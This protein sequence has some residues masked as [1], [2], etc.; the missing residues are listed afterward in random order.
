ML[1]QTCTSRFNNLRNNACRQ[2]ELVNIC[3]VQPDNIKRVVGRRVE[4]P[5]EQLLDQGDRGD[6]ED[7]VRGDLVGDG[8][9]VVVGGATGDV[10]LDCADAGTFCSVRINSDF[11]CSI[12]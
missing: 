10:L 1:P 9:V 11:K 3:A 12:F 2:R 8:H 5:T 4:S 7:S 6:F